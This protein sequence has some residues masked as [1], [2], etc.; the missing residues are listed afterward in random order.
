ME[1]SILSFMRK[2]REQLHIRALWPSK[3][4]VNIDP[5]WV[6]LDIQCH[7]PWS[8]KNL[9]IKIETLVEQDNC[10]YGQ[11]VYN[12]TIHSVDLCTTLKL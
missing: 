7:H 10:C 1:T 4:C 2:P 12:L 8:A 6:V 3:T 11:I 9:K 5:R